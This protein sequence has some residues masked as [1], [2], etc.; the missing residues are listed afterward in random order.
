VTITITMTS[1]KP[2]SPLNT[3]HLP[4]PVPEVCSMATSLLRL[5]QIGLSAA[6]RLR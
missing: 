4:R 2:A 6:T 5:R 1:K 3:A